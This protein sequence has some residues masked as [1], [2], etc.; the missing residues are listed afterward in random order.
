MA[1]A[2]S[3]V[4]HRRTACIPCEWLREFSLEKMLGYPKPSAEWLLFLISVK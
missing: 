3:N 1:D 4:V 2:L